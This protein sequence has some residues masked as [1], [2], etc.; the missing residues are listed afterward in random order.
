MFS[1]EKEHTQKFHIKRGDFDKDEMFKHF[2]KK[3]IVGDVIANYRK[4]LNY[5]PVICFCVS[6]KHCEQMMN[7]FINAGYM[8][9]MVYGNMPKK[10][11]EAAL[12]GL[13]N[14]SINVVT[15]CDVISEGVDVPVM[16]GCVLLR[17][18]MSL[19][20]YLQ[21]VGRSLRK[22]EGKENAIILDH[23]GNYHLHGP[24]LAE[25]QWS[26]TN[27]KRNR[28]KE[29]PPTT[30]RCPKCF[31]IWDGEP[32]RCPL[33]KFDFSQNEKVGTQQRKS[34]EVIK[35]ELHAVLPPDIDPK[36]V[37]DL[38]EFIC[39]IQAYDPKKR[40][41]AMLAM[42]FKLQE[43]HKIDALCRVIGFK[44]GWSKWA[45]DYVNKNRRK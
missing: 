11:R 29:K 19:A 43:R 44:P 16:A 5:K 28:R 23:A 7:E 30:T 41:K 42:A 18:T 17:R 26:L 39:R 24:I 22:Y 38:S 25:R 6:I 3:Y 27:E 1:P 4:Y 9:V 14:G 8:A 2:S 13:A 20:L 10:D 34:P 37:H 35:G 15:S 21:Q 36:D 12:F 45:W 40:Q 32:R 31:S 33:C